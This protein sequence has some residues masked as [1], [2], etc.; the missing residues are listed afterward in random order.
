M[1]D[2]LAVNEKKRRR[3]PQ[4]FEGVSRILKGML[5]TG[6]ITLFF[7]LEK[8]DPNER[9]KLYYEGKISLKVFNRATYRS[10]GFESTEDKDISASNL[11]NVLKSFFAFLAK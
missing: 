11:E 6:Q 10:I 7:R 5:T 3:S 2:V 9:P 1:L 4:E 8:T